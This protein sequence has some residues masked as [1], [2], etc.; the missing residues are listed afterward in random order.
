MS[1]KWRQSEICI[2]NND[3]LQGR[4]Q[5]FKDRIV[6]FFYTFIIQSACKRIFKIGEHLAKL[7]ANGNCFM[8][9]I[10]IALLFSK[11]LISPDDLNNLCITDRNCC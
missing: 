6:T 4:C 11:M 1:E 9:P 7:Q 10:R 2:V 8:R 3:K 5:A